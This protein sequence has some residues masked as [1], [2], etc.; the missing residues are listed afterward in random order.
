L[1]P[2]FFDVFDV[3]VRSIKGMRATTNCTEGNIIA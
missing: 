2:C 1:I 3:M